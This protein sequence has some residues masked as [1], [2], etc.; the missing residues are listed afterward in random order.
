MCRQSVIQYLK[1]HEPSEQYAEAIEKLINEGDVKPILKSRNIATRFTQLLKEVKV[2]DPAIGSG[3]FPMG[4]LYVL[5]HAIHHLHSYAE[6]HGNFDSTQTKRDIIQNNIFGVDIEQGAVDIARLRFWLALVVDA[7]K[8]QPLPNLDYK[9]T[10]GNSLLSRYPIDAPIENV[11]VEYNKG[12][13]EDE[14]M[15]LAKYKELVSDYTN[16][17]NHQTKELFRKT[18]E[19]IK[20][21]FKTELSKQF[22]ERLAKLRGKVIMLEGPTL[23]GERTKAEKADLK[24]LKKKLNTL[25]KEQEDIQTNKLYVDAFEWRFEFPQ[26]LNDDGNFMG[27]DIVIGNPPYGVSIKGE[28]RKAVVATLG[29]VP[30]YEIY[31]YFIECA[32]KQ[33]GDKGIL[34]Y[35]ILNTWLFNTFAAKYRLQILDIW[36]IIEIL[37]CTKF[38][39]FESATVLNTIITWRKKQSLES[40]T[41]GYRN[42]AR[43]LN[44]RELIS[45]SRL[46]LEILDLL[47]LNQN[48][49]LA[50]SKSQNV[51]QLIGKIKSNKH[52]LLEIF[53]DISQGLIA[54]D[55]YRGQSADIISSRAYH[56]FEYKP[57][58][59][60]WLWGEDV[61]RYEVKWNNQE[62]IDYCDGIANPRQPKFFKDKRLL[63][64][65]ITNPSIYAT[66]TSEELYNDPSMLIILDNNNNYA[67]EIVLAILNSKLATF[68]H[69]NHSPKATK[70][71]F[72]KIL[73]QDLKEFP[74]PSITFEE[75]QSISDLV[76]KIL[77]S[78][79]NDPQIDTSDL[80]NQIDFLVYKLYGLTYDEVLIVDPETNISREEYEKI[81]CL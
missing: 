1:T 69:F 28:Y 35:I 30:D 39:I 38:P 73:V 64:R 60:K 20:C 68:Y 48:W 43:A 80:E 9:I 29:N 6:P 59:K 53:S 12:K 76:K 32:K 54:Y 70:G 61:R 63:V 23:F 15:S 72:P 19:D 66:I 58:L 57:G 37:D 46:Y 18:I 5:Y 77:D 42:T 2:C 41:V 50:F 62:Y 27:F 8:P 49:G 71:A 78:K 65:E 33:L 10:C 25:E 22:K 55:K 31:Y 21:A 52:L 7:D 11:F 34:S 14:K 79:K 24:K 47:Q 13:K 75:K 16:T 67:L 40:I 45:E 56:S 51:I 3:A 17:S 74:L 81:N 26:L 44:F 4:I 36:N